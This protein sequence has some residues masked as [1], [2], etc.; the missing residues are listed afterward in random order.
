MVSEDGDER[1]ALELSGNMEVA[2]ALFQWRYQSG[3]DGIVQRLKTQK[4]AI[5]LAVLLGAVG[6][7]GIGHFYVGRIRRGLLLLIGAWGLGGASLFCF[8]T[9]AMSAMVVPPPGYPKVEVP[10]YSLVLFAIGVVLLLGL[11]ALWIWQIFNAKAACQN[12]NKQV[13]D[14]APRSGFEG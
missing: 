1:R 11:V 5:V 6:F 7:L 4:I 2:V 14:R 12:Y 3:E 10:T 9:S 13:S 8:I